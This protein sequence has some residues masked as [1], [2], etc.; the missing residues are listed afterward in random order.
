MF[1]SPRMKEK[2]LLDFTVDDN[3]LE[4]YQSDNI[5]DFY[6]VFSAQQINSPELI[7]TDE[8]RWEMLYSIH[9]FLHGGSFDD[10]GYTVNQSELRVE[11]IFVKYFNVEQARMQFDDTYMQGEKKLQFALA[12]TQKIQQ[13]DCPDDMEKITLAVKNLVC[14]MG[15]TVQNQEKFS[16]LYGTLF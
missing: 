15:L 4:F 12:L 13:T 9:E 5:K 6:R 7:W 14:N 10:F 2:L 8:T 16:E 3:Q 1:F 11:G